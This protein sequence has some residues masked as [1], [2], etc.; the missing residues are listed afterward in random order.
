MRAPIVSL[1]V[2]LVAVSPAGAWNATGHKL[3][4]SL[5]FRQLSAADQGRV[6]AILQRHPRFT[7]DFADEMPPEVKAGDEAMQN[8]WLFQQAGIW[9]DIVRGGPPERTAFHRPTWHYVDL[10]HF[11]NDTTRA[12]LDGQIKE[13]VALDPPPTATP[14]LQEMNVTQT[15]RLARRLAADKQAAPETRALMLAWLFH[16]VGDLHQ[17]C[18]S[19]QLYSNRLFPEGDQGANKI[20]LV[21]SFNLHALW[22]GFLGQDAEFRAVRNRAIAMSADAKWM[23]L[24]QEAAADLDAKSWR[25]E[26]HLV[27]VTVVYDAELMIALRKVEASADPPEPLTLSED[28]LRMGGR[29]AER[30][31][32][33]ASYRLAAVLKAIVA[34]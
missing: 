32:V 29:N 12:D 18:H 31:V 26:S 20:K 8:E 5:A 11:L 7:P 34:D 15:I 17:P 6:V 27:A 24:G 2:C 25:D 4:S 9:A 30:R 13:N 33:Q 21:Q 19:T 10:P 28:Y 16:A 3:I 23:K 14:E 1:L 22:D